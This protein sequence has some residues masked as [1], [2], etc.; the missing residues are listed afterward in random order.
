MKGLRRQAQ[1]DDGKDVLART[2]FWEQSF[3][4]SASG[5]PQQLTFKACPSISPWSGSKEKQYA[6]ISQEEQAEKEETRSK[7]GKITY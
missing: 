7:N 5:L 6:F 1:K 2:F 3:T 4:T